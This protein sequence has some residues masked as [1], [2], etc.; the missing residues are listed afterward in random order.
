M[1]TCE[2]MNTYESQKTRISDVLIQIFIIDKN[3]ETMSGM[4]EK[5]TIKELSMEQ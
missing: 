1:T 5:V 4:T 2:S 3:L